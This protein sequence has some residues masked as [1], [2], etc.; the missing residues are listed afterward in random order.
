MSPTLTF[1]SF[2]S[3]PYFL[4]I[5]RADCLGTFFVQQVILILG[6]VI[7]GG[8]VLETNINQIAE[9]GAYFLVGSEIFL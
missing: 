3:N 1:E 5:V 9:R 7:Q 8:L 6:E 2:G 4:S